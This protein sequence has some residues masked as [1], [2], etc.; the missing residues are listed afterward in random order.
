MGNFRKV[1]ATT[2]LSSGL[3]E[4][5]VVW[6]GSD[7]RFNSDLDW[8]SIAAFQAAEIAKVGLEEIEKVEVTFSDDF[9]E[10]VEVKDFE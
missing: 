8:F 5:K 10:W 9:E 4:N 6:E 2:T 7:R 3:I 1:S